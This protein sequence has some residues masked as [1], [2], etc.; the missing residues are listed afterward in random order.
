[1]RRPV[2]RS[3]GFYSPEE[4][5]VHKEK[6]GR[7]IIASIISVVFIHAGCIAQ[8]KLQQ[9]ANN[10]TLNEVSWLAGRWKSKNE[11]PSFEEHWMTPHDGCMVGMGRETSG[12]KMAFFEYLRIEQR[13]DGLF[14]VA[15]PRGK[16]PTDFK[17]TTKTSSSL[18]FENPQHDFPKTIEYEKRPNNSLLVRVSGDDTKEKSFQHILFKF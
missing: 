14:Y 17:L 8:T 11:N 16:S 7:P 3:G 9:S 18:K 2:L 5:L 12:K 13:E 1:M 6:L 10:L 4:Q 15:Q